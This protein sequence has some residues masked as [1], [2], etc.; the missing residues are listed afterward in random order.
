[1]NESIKVKSMVV[2]EE[3]ERLSEVI[4]QLD[5]VIDSVAFPNNRP[6]RT[7]QDYHGPAFSLKGFIKFICT[8]GQ[9][10][11]IY[12][13]LIGHPR[14][15]YLVTVILDTSMSMAGMSAV[16]ATQGFLSLA[17]EGFFIVIVVHD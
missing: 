4:S 6:T 13:N 7:M 3:E 14:K 11:K 5:N 2:C 1:M 16:G 12:E 10:K 9:Y 17:G 8:D 15:D